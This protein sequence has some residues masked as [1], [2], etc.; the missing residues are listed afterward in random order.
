[1]PSNKH[2]HHNHLQETC[3]DMMWYR[4]ISDDMTNTTQMYVIEFRRGRFMHACSKVSLFHT[5]GSPDSL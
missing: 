1:M 5:D 4:V 3:P 2:N